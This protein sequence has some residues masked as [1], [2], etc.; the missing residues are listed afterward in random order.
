MAGANVE[1]TEPR[2]SHRL[3]VSGT[4]DTHTLSLTLPLSVSLSLYLSVSPKLF[5]PSTLFT[6]TASVPRPYDAACRVT[7]DTELLVLVQGHVV[8]DLVSA[9]HH[10]RHLYHLFLHP[11]VWPT[12]LTAPQPLYPP[13]AV[14]GENVSLS[15]IPMGGFYRPSATLHGVS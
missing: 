10:H 12:T 6:F 4:P 9:R 7:R 13:T 2:H 11:S 14:M 1:L 15:E 3:G 5:T 8:I